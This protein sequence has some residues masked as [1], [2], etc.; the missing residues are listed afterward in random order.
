M[1]RPALFSFGYPSNQF[2]AVAPCFSLKSKVSFF[3]VIEAGEGVSY[4]HTFRATKKT[5]I[6]TI[7]IG[8]G[9][10]YRRALSNKASVLIRG[11]KYPIAGNI[12]MDQFMVDIGD[13]EAYVGDEVVLIGKQG[14]E[15][16]KLEEIAKLC[17]TIPYEILCGFNERSPRRY[18]SD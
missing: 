2:V 12:C 5:R 4:G 13:G 15:E 3:K 16:I 11:K 1:V 10:G 9:D 14:S 8:Y 18:L 6:A 17:D 7:A